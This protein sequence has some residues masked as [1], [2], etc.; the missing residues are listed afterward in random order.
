MTR[1]VLLAAALGLPLALAAAVAQGPEA[2]RPVHVARL[3]GV[4]APSAVQFITTSLQ[5]AQRDR[6][7]ALVIELDTPGGL[8]VSMRAII[9]EIMAS[10]V[11]IVVYV[12]PSGARAA[13]AGAFLTLA[14]HVAAMAPG[15]N[16]G[17][18]H[19]VSMGGEMDKEMAR[20][21][22][23]DAAAYIRSIAEKRGRSVKWAEDAVRK[24]VSATEKE[25]LR[26]GVIDLVS[27]RLDDLLTKIDGRRVEVPSGPVT[28]RTKG[29]PL[30]RIEPSFR[31]RVL[32]VISDPTIAYILLLL[33]LAGLYFEFST[34]GAIL[35]GILGGI[36]LILAFYAFQTLPINY[37]G[38]LLILLAVV[39]FIAEAMVVSHGILTMGGVV[40]MLLGSMMLIDSPAPYMRISVSAILGA[41][42]A[43]TAFFVLLVGAAVRAQRGSPKTG[44]EGLLGT[45]GV[46]RTRLAPGGLV[47]VQGAIWSAEAAEVVESGEPVEVVAIDGLK[48]KVQKVKTDP[49]AG[50]ARPDSPA[51]G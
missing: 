33:G 26:L 5:Q 17:A 2:P 46:A 37:A 38:L 6:A 34:P 3:E 39:L 7:V 9:K 45:V 12:S 24:S 23:N 13:S 42:A 8:D 27:E 10:E 16:I 30:V 18:A 51:A 41:T 28:L 48:L 29:A 47:F 40:S 35:P 25:A 11:P 1:R 50:L 21:V 32:R 20:K 4:I 36:F 43:T 44:K 14:A 49:A 19:P 22:T 15:T 31:D